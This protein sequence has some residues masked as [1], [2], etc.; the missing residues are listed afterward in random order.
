MRISD[1]SSDVCSS[2]LAREQGIADRGLSLAPGARWRDAAVGIT[3]VGL[4]R[5]AA[6]V[7]NAHAAHP[8]SGD[9]AI[10]RMPD[11]PDRKAIA[12]R[13]KTA[14]NGACPPRQPTDRKSTRLN[15]SH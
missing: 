11:S 5:G 14:R 10:G 2:D 4:V 8:G 12:D 3:G 1:W 7:E 13:P 15:S 6:M 9:D